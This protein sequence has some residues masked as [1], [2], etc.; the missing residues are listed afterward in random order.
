[1]SEKRDCTELETE[2]DRECSTV[3][4]ASPAMTG[5]GLWLEWL[6]SEPVQTIADGQFKI[7]VQ[8][9]QTELNVL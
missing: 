7:I 8:N 5:I 3:S 1:V 4:L 6:D 9:A 2:S